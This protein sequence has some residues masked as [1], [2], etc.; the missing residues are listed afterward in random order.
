LIKGRE[1]ERER[2]RG[3]RFWREGRGSRAFLLSSRQHGALINFSPFLRQTK[4]RI[5]GQ[6]MHTC[7]IVPYHQQWQISSSLMYIY[8]SVGW[9]LLLFFLFFSL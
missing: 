6:N 8:L 1:R 9:L 4:K 3:M 7:I 5:G 2:E